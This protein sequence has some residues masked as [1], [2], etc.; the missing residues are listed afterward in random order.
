MTG[1]GSSI[2]KSKDIEVSVEVRSVNNRFMDISLKLPK[3]L[4]NYEQNIRGLVNHYVTR[5][6]INIWVVL[7]QE[8]EKYE[9]LELNQGLV[10]AYLRLAKEVSEKYNVPNNLDV[11]QIFEL[12]D[13]ISFEPEEAADERIWACTEESLKEAMK[14]L[15]DMRKREGREIYKDFQTRISLLQ[16]YIND[17]EDIAENGPEIEMDKMRQ[18]VRKIIAGKKVDQDR[19]ET[20]M[21]IIAD[22]IDITEECTRFR[23]HNTAFLELLDA[24]TSQG[25]K[26]NFLLQEMNREANTMASKAFTSDISHLVV[27]IKEEVEKIREQVQNIE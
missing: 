14:Q 11:R 6:R 15:N 10:E 22:K 3:S 12:P 26:L 23:S 25:R 5:G 17:I 1:Y 4:S 7:K 18:R 16:K 9:N 24:E 27:K 21:A 19:L 8:E 20:E 13:V 2:K